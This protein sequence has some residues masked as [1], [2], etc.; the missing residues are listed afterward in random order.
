[1]TTFRSRII[2][3]PH[4]GNLMSTYELTSYFVHSSVAYSDGKVDCN[5]PRME[6]KKILICS[7]CNKEF[8]R[9][10]A[11]L[12]RENLNISYN[13]LP[14]AKDFIDLTYA[15]DNDYTSKLATYFS[16]LLERGFA[17]TVKKEVYLRIKLW[18]LLNNDIRSDSDNFIKNLGKYVLGTLLK[19]TH[20]KRDSNNSNHFFKSNL[21][22]LISIYKPENDEMNLMLAEMHRELGDFRQ[23]LLILKEIENIDNKVAYK[24]IRAAAKRKKIK[25]LKL[26]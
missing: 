4:C 2:Q 24:K 23:A 15:F 9:D 8:W 22:R 3:C 25:V 14:E 7:D 18:Q 12:E 20:S 16:K 10:D 21:K 11:F 5:P 19:K 1:M 6:D 17:D 13:E 26:N